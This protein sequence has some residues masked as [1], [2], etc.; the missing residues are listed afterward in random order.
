MIFG[1]SIALVLE[2]ILVI[3]LI[4]GVA[5]SLRLAHLVGAGIA[6][7]SFY[8][9]AFALFLI[10]LARL[11]LFM[12][13]EIMPV[14][15]DVTLH[16]WWHLIS[17]C[18]L[19]SMIW[20]GYRQ[21]RAIS[22]SKFDGFGAKDAV[23]MVVALIVSLLTFFVATPWEPVLAE[24]LVG[25]SI[26]QIGVHHFVVMALGFV[27]SLYVLQLR[28]FWLNTMFVPT[29]IFLSSIGVQ[30]LWELFTESWVL[31]TLTTAT[32]E[33]TEQVMVLVGLV[34]IIYGLAQSLRA[35]LLPINKS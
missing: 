3:L 23:F 7:I 29:V 10:L 5:M 35:M 28:S 15:S 25:S 12:F 8:F 32:I 17:S 6:N 16:V 33:T 2:V 13:S 20:A 22:T 1:L 18:A 26:D 21:S 4:V 11:F 14:L 9:L 31:I 30:H 27:T 24:F 34:G 19:G